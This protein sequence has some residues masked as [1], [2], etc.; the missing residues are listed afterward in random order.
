VL[1]VDGKAI[2]RGKAFRF[3]H[4][5]RIN[6]YDLVVWIQLESDQ[7]VEIALSPAEGR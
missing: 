2:P 3:G 5:R 1:Q 4:I 6:R 7:T